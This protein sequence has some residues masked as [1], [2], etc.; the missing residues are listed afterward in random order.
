MKFSVLER[1]NLQVDNVVISRV[2]EK[3]IHK[4][5]DENETQEGKEEY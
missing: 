1:L 2:L 4:S 3:E 5:K